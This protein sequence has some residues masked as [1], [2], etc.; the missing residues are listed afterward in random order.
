MTTTRKAMHAGEAVAEALRE[1]GVERIYSVP[2]S[3]IHPIYDGLSRVPSVKFI[4]CKTEPNTSLMADA[5][6]RLTGKPGVCLV[7]AGPG[8][9]NSMAG[10]GQA[11]GAASPMVHLSG[12]VPLQA[13]MEAFHGVDDPAFVHEMFKKIT[14]WSARVERIEDIPEVM[15]KA[16]H[17]ARSGRP[18]PVHVELPRVSDYSEYILQETPAVLPE[19]KRIPTSVV[20]P[21]AGLVDRCARRLMEARSPVL[22]AG[23][24][25]LRQGAQAQLIALAE[26]LQAPVIF[27]QD[28]IGIIP[29]AHPLF[30][31]YFQKQRSHPLCVDAIANTDLILAVGLRAGAAEMTE[32]RER[33]P[34]K[35]LVLIGFDDAQTAHYRGEDERVADPRLFLEALLARI[36][37]YQRGKNEAMLEQMAAK[38]AELRQKLATIVAPHAHDAPIYPGVLMLAMN[39]V[40]DD[41]AVVASDVGLCQMWARVFRRIATPESFMQSGVWNAMSNGLPTA[42]VA[43]MEFPERDVIG[44]AGDGAS[45]MTIGDLPTATEYGAN[46]V[47]VVLNDGSFGQTYLQ[48]TGLYGHTYGTA[49]TSPNFAQI[50][51]ACGCKGIRVTEP[52]DVEDALKRALAATKTQPAVVEVMVGRHVQ[53]KI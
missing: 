47:L 30:A 53:P 27:A 38:K 45:L 14:K 25:V 43:K 48:Q 10:V 12:A 40:L 2:G 5:Y 18:G 3:H 36:G 17:I 23:K 33:A 41:R 11:Y 49:F 7:T 1:E 42:I 50:G 16:F 4:T 13:D 34:E 20:T 6:G 9:I 44:L 32:L 24:G 46:I 15:A 51:E 35:N 37:D 52:K 8:C 28:C 31:G 29:E 19:Y 22:A 26:R 39:K 21:D